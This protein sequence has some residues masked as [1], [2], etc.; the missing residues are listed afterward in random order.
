MLAQILLVFSTLHQIQAEITCIIPGYELATDGNCYM[1]T[2]R[3]TQVRSTCMYLMP[4]TW[5]TLVLG[6]E[7]VASLCGEGAELVILDGGD[8]TNLAQVIKPFVTKIS[9]VVTELHIF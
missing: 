2:Q 6:Q 5:I 4:K 3:E 1:V 8:Q 7:N 9:K